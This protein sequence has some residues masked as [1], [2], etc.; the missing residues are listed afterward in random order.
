VD[1]IMSAKLHGNLP[2]EA[3]MKAYSHECNEDMTTAEVEE[4]VVMCTEQ[5]L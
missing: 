1:S 2:A 4:P 5:D 3:H